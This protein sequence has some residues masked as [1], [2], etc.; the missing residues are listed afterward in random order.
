MKTIRQEL[1]RDA[2]RRHTAFAQE[3]ALRRYRVSRDLWPEIASRTPASRWLT[4]KDRIFRFLWVALTLALMVHARSASAQFQEADAGS[5]VTPGVPATAF[6]WL[7][8]I[9]L[10]VTVLVSA[11]CM[12]WFCSPS[13]QRPGGS[14]PPAQ[15]S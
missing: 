13:R 7:I 3:Q 6:A 4:W 15:P 5:V 14:T 2:W 10:A 11:T 12:L 8:Q 9:A 1:E